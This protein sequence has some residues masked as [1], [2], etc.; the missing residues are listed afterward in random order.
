MIRIEKSLNFKGLSFRGL[1]FRGLSFR[2]TLLP[3]SKTQTLTRNSII[4][5]VFSPN[6]NRAF[7]QNVVPLWICV[8]RIEKILNFKGAEFSGSE[9]SG[10]EFS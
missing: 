8:I 10:S 2:D 3:V 9:F 4:L 6:F 5:N 1:S 7:G